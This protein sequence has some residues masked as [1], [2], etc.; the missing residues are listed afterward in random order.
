MNFNSVTGKPRRK[1]CYK[2]GGS[3]RGEVLGPVG[4]PGICQYCLRNRV[5]TAEQ[6]AD[7]KRKGKEMYEKLGGETWILTN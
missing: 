7:M 3:L 6:I 5:W 1:E 2:C 4:T